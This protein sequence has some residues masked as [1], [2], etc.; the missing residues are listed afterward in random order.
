MLFGCGSDAVLAITEM[1][2]DQ[3]L[4]LSATLDVDRSNVFFKGVPSPGDWDLPSFDECVEPGSSCESCTG[5]HVAHGLSG[6]GVS[7]V[8]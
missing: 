6:P 3:I 1:G 8:T 4:S 2:Q 7:G 5:R